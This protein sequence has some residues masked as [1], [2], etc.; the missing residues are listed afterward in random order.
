MKTIIKTSIEV[1]LILNSKE[2]F[3]LKSITQNPLVEGESEDDVKM[4]NL[5]FVSLP[6]FGELLPRGE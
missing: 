1:T 3:W 5:F 2:A 4:R 6:T